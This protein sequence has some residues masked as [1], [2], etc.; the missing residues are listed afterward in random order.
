[1]A[2]NI[3]CASLDMFLQIINNENYYKHFQLAYPFVKGRR[4]I[5]FD[6]VDDPIHSTKLG[7]VMNPFQFSTV[8][9]DYP[10]PYSLWH[11]L[12]NFA[13]NTGRLLWN[14]Y[15]ETQAMEAQVSNANY[16][17]YVLLI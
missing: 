12:R 14:R 1:M 6:I 3:C 5:K 16:F 13:E 11:Q 8:F 10:R 15:I 7:N 9:S 4:F 2:K 17:Y